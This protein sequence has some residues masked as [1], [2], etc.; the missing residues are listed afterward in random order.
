MG[1]SMEIVISEEEDS[2]KRATIV[3]PWGDVSADYDDAFRKF[4]NAAVPGFRKGKVP[5]EII[6]KHFQ[7][8][9]SDIAKKHAAARLTRDAL[10]Q[11]GLRSVGGIAVVEADL[12]PNQDFRCVAEFIERPDF[13]LPDYSGLTLSSDEDDARRDEITDWFLAHVSIAIPERLVREELSAENPDAQSG[14]M[15]WKY[16]EKRVRALMIFKEIAE[17]EG[18]DV[19]DN[20]LQER[21]KIMATEI[22]A[23]PK[24]LEEHLIATGGV[25][26]LKEFMLAEATLTFL[27]EMAVASKEQK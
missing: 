26:R 21:I 27:I 4:R 3:V 17:N 25:A 24:Q 16:A 9:I 10:R 12:S 6:R 14:S 15:E 7:K 19:S 20:E 11:K 18:I 5:P 2:L 8:E 23:T 1:M 22:G 13:M